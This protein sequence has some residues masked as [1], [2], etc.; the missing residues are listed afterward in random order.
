MQ[1]L[2]VAHDLLASVYGILFPDQ[3]WKLGPLHWE[4]GV[5]AN[6]P[7]HMI[8]YGILPELLK[9]LKMSI[10]HA[11]RDYIGLGS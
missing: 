4:H 6:G 7:P 5:L 2:V 10:C 3:G 8:L 9:I 1:N 11:K